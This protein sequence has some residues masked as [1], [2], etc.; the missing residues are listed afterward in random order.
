MP[1]SL[2]PCWLQTPPL[3]TNTQVAPAVLSS[4]GPPT[5]A[6]LP[7]PDSATEAPWDHNPPPGALVV[8]T[9]LLPCWVHAPPL[10][11]KIHAAPA[12]PTDGARSRSALLGPGPPTIAILPSADNATDIPWF[13]V[14]PASV[15]NGFDASCNPCAGASSPEAVCR[16]CSAPAPAPFLGW[17]GRP[18]F[19]A[20]FRSSSGL[21][22]NAVIF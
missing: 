14:P 21:E 17:L 13:A 8:P 1:T 18:G 3:R 4:L 19:K 5:I 7:S 20:K 22:S 11:M 9:N 15:P 6:V 12:G 2:S 16:A 10:R